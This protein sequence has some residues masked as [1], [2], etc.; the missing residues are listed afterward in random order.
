MGNMD[1]DLGDA[2]AGGILGGWGMVLAPLAGVFGGVFLAEVAAADFDFR[3]GTI[4]AEVFLLLPYLTFT[5]VYAFLL[6]LGIAGAL[7][8]FLL[9][10]ENRLEAVLGLCWLTALQ[11]FLYLVRDS[12]DS[13][14]LWDWLRIVGVFAML[15]A[16]YM[17]LRIYVRRR[18]LR[19]VKLLEEERLHRLQEP[20]QEGQEHE[21]DNR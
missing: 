12:W 5:S 14:G 16:V 10:E 21:G 7:L 4:L 2:I 8:R 17:P 9:N 3:P 15:P 19:M 6:N 20:A 13:L 11:V 1:H 18:Y